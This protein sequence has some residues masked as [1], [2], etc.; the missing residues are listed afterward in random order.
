[1]LIEGWQHFADDLRGDNPLLPPTTWIGAME[2]AG[3]AEARAWPRAGSVAEGVAQHV[4]VGRAPGDAAGGA[5]LTT[6]GGVREAAGVAATAS[7][8]AT[9]EWLERFEQAMPV[10]RLDLLRDRVREEVM[11]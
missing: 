9:N 7:A 3:F 6:V 5:V 4:I 11:R 10:E 2:Q 8:T 1:G